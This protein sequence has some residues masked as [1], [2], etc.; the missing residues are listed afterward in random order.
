M[1]L[2]L[3]SVNFCVACHAINW[4]Y[5]IPNDVCAFFDI[6]RL[7]LFKHLGSVIGASLINGF[8]FF[9][10]VIADLFRTCVGNPKIK[11]N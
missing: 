1:Y 11:D 3:Y 5:H 9:P 6:V 7:L 10:E 4:Y 8:L 2:S